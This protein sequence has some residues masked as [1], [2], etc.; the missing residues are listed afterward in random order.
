MALDRASA[1]PIVSD[2][3][4]AHVS[5]A[6]SLLR[7][8]PQRAQKWLLVPACKPGTSSTARPRWLPG[9]NAIVKRSSHQPRAPRYVNL[10]V[11]P[12]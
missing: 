7:K 4:V 1:H 3:A 9:L 5:T 10:R 8:P 6:E 2:A 12:P 11:Q